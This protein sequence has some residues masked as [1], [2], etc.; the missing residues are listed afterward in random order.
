MVSYSGHQMLFPTLG[1][2][3]ST[4]R[5]Q[6]YNLEFPFMVNPLSCIWIAPA[7]Q[8]G[9]QTKTSPKSL[10]LMLPR[11]LDKA[12]AARRHRVVRVATTFMLLLCS[13]LEHRRRP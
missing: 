11:F 13:A 5:L 1:S 12:G 6:K 10:T 8:S 3:L 4:A 9:A 2:Q 7:A